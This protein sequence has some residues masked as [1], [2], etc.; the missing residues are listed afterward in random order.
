MPI[1]SDIQGSTGGLYLLL[2]NRPERYFYP[3]YTQGY[4]VY[5]HERG[6]GLGDSEIPSPPGSITKISIQKEQYQLLEKGNG[7]KCEKRSLKSGFPRPSSKVGK[8]RKF[9][10]LQTLS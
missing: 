10:I 5:I 3:K 9:K 2:K 8:M 1:L 4:K 7:G 6:T